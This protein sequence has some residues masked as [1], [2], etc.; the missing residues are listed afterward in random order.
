[1]GQKGL[2]MDIDVGHTGTYYQRSAG[3]IGNAAVKYLN[4][5]YK[6]NTGNKALFCNPQADSE[7]IKAGWTIW[8]K[9]GMC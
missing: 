9:N 7:F 3:K 2:W 5:Q 8:A 1:V 6:N 4:W